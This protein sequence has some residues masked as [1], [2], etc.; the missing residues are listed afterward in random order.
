[1]PERDVM[2]LSEIYLDA[3]SAPKMFTSR[4]KRKKKQDPHVPKYK[5][6]LKVISIKVKIKGLFILNST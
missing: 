5:G 3:I 1:M 4:W 2:A 6:I